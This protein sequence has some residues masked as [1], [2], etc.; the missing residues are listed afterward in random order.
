MIRGLILIIAANWKMNPGLAEAGA[1]A[2]SYSAVRFQNVIRIV[3]PPH[4]YLVQMSVLL[5][6]SGIL[7][8]GQDCHDQADG[9]HTGDVSGDMLAACGASIVLLGHSERRSAHGETDDLVAAKARRALDAGMSVMICVGETLDQRQA[10]NA[11][12]VVTSQLA[13][14]IPK[15]VEA[16]HLVVAYEPVWAIGTGKV[17]SEAEISAMHDA[18][19][20]WMTDAGLAKV[21]LLYGGSVKPDNADAIFAV[22][23]VDGALVGGAS[24]NA[25]DFAAICAAGERVKPL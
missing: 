17:A 9:A 10:G 19:R 4:P 5:G 15:G 20:A 6:D 14:S 8:G 11:E 22:D 21:P 18:I 7:L 16:D 12:S 1:L 25:D 2:S 23:N 3:F 24:L 13:G